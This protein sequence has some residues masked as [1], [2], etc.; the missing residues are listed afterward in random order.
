MIERG[1]KNFDQIADRAA[2]L[3][4]KDIIDAM[5]A[6]GIKNPDQ[7]ASKVSR[8]ITRYPREWNRG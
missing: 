3:G 8:G 4:Y 6:K 2:C 1:A 5:I 7:V